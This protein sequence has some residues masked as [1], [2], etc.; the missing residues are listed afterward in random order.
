M[1]Q[2][3]WL[4]HPKSHDRAHWDLR[5]PAGLCRNFAANLPERYDRRRTVRDSYSEKTAQICLHRYNASPAIT[6]LVESRSRHL[7]STLGRWRGHGWPIIGIFHH[8]HSSSTAISTSTSRRGSA[9]CS[10]WRG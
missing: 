2:T 6:G 9:R 5:Q 1:K 7:N 4:Q 8:Q 10:C 3:R